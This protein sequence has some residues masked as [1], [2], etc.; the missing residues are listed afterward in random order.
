MAAKEKDAGS[1]KLDDLD[2]D[3]LRSLNANARKSFRD[4]AK[5]LHV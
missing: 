3:I 2:I 4:I 1:I 5:E